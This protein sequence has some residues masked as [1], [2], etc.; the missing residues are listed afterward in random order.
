MS[1]L[2]LDDPRLVVLPTPCAIIDVDA[3]KRNIDTMADRARQAGIALRPHAKTHKCAEIARLQLATGAAGIACATIGEAEALAHAGIDRLMITSPLAGQEKYGRA[4]R[5]A[6]RAELILTIDH[7]DHL[8]QIEAKHR[9]DDRPISVLVELDVGQGRSGTSSVA[10]AISLAERVV[11]SKSVRFR[12]IQGF[13]GQVQHIMDY[14]SRE[15]GAQQVADTLREAITGLRHRG[16]AA[17]IVTGGGTGTFSFDCRGPFNEVQVGSYVF[18]DADY[19]RVI[20]ADTSALPFE[21]SLFIF[22]TVVSASHAGQVTVDAGTKALAFNGPAPDLILGAPSGATY[23]FAG[24]EHGIVRFPPDSEP[25]RI[26]SRML[27]A[28]SHC[29]PTVNLYGHYV[30]VS[31]KHIEN[32]PLLGRH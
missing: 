13:A 30:A 7:I 17:D 14:H 19:R 32:W 5:L 29:D 28:A 2:R 18:M 15:H 21:Q 4:M 31:G 12:G 24:D 16:M 6:D 23:G 25:P 9:G 11:A 10:A 26:G 22:A 8:A 20:D 3:L 1:A 27:L